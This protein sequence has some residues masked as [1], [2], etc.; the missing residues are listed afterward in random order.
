MKKKI[1]T[2]LLPLIKCNKILLLPSIERSVVHSHYLSFESTAW[3]RMIEWL[4]EWMNEW[5]DEWV[6]IVL[7]LMNPAML[8]M[9]LLMKRRIISN[10]YIHLISSSLQSFSQKTWIHPLQQIQSWQRLYMTNPS[11]YYSLLDVF[12]FIR[13]SSAHHLITKNPSFGTPRLY[14]NRIEMRIE[15]L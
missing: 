9:I 15:L 13:T 8:M 2:N 3:I 1:K 7:I 14:I 6:T 11:C 5:L 12:R 10:P 4:T